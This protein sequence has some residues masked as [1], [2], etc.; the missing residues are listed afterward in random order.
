MF[1]TVN[2]LL[3]TVSSNTITPSHLIYLVELL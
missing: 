3:L 1:G 2:E